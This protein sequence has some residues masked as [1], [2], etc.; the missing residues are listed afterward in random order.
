MNVAIGRGVPIRIKNTFEPDL[1]GTAVFPPDHPEFEFDPPVY[2]AK[3][4]TAK[5]GVR[6]IDVTSNK[7]YSSSKFLASVFT[8]LSNHRI[9]VDLASTSEVKISVA[10][11]EQIHDWQIEQTLEDLKAFADA[12]LVTNKA[13]LSII[14]EGIR[15][16]KGVAAR[17][18][19]CLADEGINIEMITQ[20][21]S[22]VNV[23]CVVPE[24]QVDEAMIAVHKGL[25]IP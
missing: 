9:I 1:S 14:G 24:D 7:L 21:A 19:M 6:I 5:K 17:K 4:V 13:I 12:T 16:R 2:G 11:N 20:G 22:E 25:C 18:F 3:A 23:S 10:I 15:G 8:T